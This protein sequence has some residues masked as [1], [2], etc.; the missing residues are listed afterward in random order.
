MAGNGSI[1]HQ[2]DQQR[3]WQLEAELGR[4]RELQSWERKTTENELGRLEKRIGE[5]EKDLDALKGSINAAI[6]WLAVAAMAIIFELLRKGV[7]F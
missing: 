3:L 6:R 4:L 1:S 5:T 7:V 2:L